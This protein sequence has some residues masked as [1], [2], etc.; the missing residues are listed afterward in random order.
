M[1]GSG[2]SSLTGSSDIAGFVWRHSTDGSFRSAA[3]R[4]APAIRRGVESA[5][6]PKVL[7]PTGVLFV[8]CFVRGRN[9]VSAVIQDH[10]AVRFIPFM[11]DGQIDRPASAT[12]G[13]ARR[14]F[15]TVYN[16]LFVPARNPRLTAV[17][18]RA[19]S[20]P[21]IHMQDPMTRAVFGLDR[22]AGSRRTR[23]EA[24]DLVKQRPLALRGY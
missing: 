18:N 24:S 7:N 14:R 2:T 8:P 13:D 19:E 16:G 23:E 6:I 12:G 9:P 22:P 21:L 17:V 5:L 15:L 10:T 3:F 1:T 11:V 4:H 20:M